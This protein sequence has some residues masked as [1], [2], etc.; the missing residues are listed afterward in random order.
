MKSS[1]KNKQL[2]FV[3]VDLKKGSECQGKLF[4]LL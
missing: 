2:V 1:A 3:F 4:V